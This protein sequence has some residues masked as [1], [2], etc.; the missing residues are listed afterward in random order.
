MITIQPQNPSIN[1]YIQAIGREKIEQ[2]IL[3]YLKIKAQFY[4]QTLEKEETKP[5]YKDFGISEELHNKILALKS[6]PKKSNDKMSL[7]REEINSK[8]KD[9][10]SNKSIEEIREEYFQSKGY[11]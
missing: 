6:V 1:D 8:L 3:N 11:L 2:M 9:D 4:E 10:Y 5:T 7:L